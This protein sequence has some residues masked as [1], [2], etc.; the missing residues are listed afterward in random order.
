MWQGNRNSIFMQVLKSHCLE[1]L[2]RAAGHKRVESRLDLSF[3]QAL[4]QTEGTL[5]YMYLRHTH[6]QGS[7]SQGTRARGMALTPAPSRE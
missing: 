1:A 5:Q 4:L 7:C 2:L 3:F 6:T